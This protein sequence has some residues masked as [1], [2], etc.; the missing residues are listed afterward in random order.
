MADY[1]ALYEQK[2]TTCE[3]IAKQVQSGWSLCVDAGPTHATAIIDAIA[4]KIAQ[5][6]TH[7]VDIHM[8]LDTYPYPFLQTDALKGKLTAKSW[9]SSGGLRKAVGGGYA[10][11]MPS[12]YRDIPGHLRRAYDFDACLVAVSP[13]D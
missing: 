3:E 8:L 7:G 2:R 9:F 4:E 5:T 13:M 1:R 11:V 10:D 12:Y 6:D